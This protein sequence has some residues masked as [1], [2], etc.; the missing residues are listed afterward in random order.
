MIVLCPHPNIFVRDKQFFY[1]LLPEGEGMGCFTMI[2]LL[3]FRLPL[4]PLSLWER[5]ANHRVDLNYKS[6]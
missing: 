4:R 2:L 1:G 6:G 3:S 5:A